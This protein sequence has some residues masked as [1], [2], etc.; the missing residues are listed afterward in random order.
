MMKVGI[1]IFPDVEELDFVGVYEVLAKTRAMKD[2]G[3]LPIKEPLQVDV[4][5]FEDMIACSNG[6][7][8]KPHKVIDDF[9]GYDLLIVPGGRGVE[10]L[11]DDAG[12]LEKIKD[13]AEKHMVCSVCTGALVLGKAGLLKGK[14]ATTHHEHRED[15]RKF[16]EV[17]NSRVYV[18]G[19]VI[20][21]GGVSCSL[22][23]G[24]KILEMI[25]GR[26]IAGMVADRLEIPAEIRPC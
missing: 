10:R 14:K 7:V 8:V 20:S 23:L 1:F 6:L 26:Q 4:I 18:D 13:F 9:E 15:L 24:L 17:I 25:Y 2:E 5:G 16:C 19:N 21:A 12:L 3:E 22:D 11:L